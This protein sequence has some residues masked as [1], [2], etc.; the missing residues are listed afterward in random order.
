M[1]DAVLAA[2]GAIFTPVLYVAADLADPTT[3]R[4]IVPPVV[5]PSTLPPRQKA[6]LRE[7]LL[8]MHED[9]AGKTVLQE[10]GIARFFEVENAAYDGVRRL[11]H[12]MGTGD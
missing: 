4:S 1:I 5:V 9:A 6:Q 2:P 7:L 10:L 12:A 3:L 8:P 11:V